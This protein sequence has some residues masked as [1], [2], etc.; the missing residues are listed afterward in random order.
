MTWLGNAI[1]QMLTLKTLSVLANIVFTAFLTVQLARVFEDYIKPQ[2]TRTW[3]EYA[4]LEEME[5]PLAIKICVIPGFNQ[6]ALEELGYND[7]F[8]YFLGR[9][10]YGKVCSTYGWAGHTND[11]RTVEEVLA[12]VEGYQ[13]EKIIKEV[14][15]WSGKWKESISIPF[16]CLKVSKVN[17]PNN[18]RS[19]DLSEVHRKKGTSYNQLFVKIR[20]LGDYTIT[21]HF[22]GKSLDTGRN[23]REHNLRSTGDNIILTQGW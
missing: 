14:Y 13:L 11:S 20:E 10:D 4:R 7:T 1:T 22:N 18:C 23:I 16:G 6:T 3:D 17:F 5:F 12:K 2:T 15:V 21:V 19:V 9:E 8:S